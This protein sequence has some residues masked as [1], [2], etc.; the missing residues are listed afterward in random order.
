MFRKIHQTKI[1]QRQNTPC[2]LQNLVAFY[3]KK[4]KAS[5]QQR[6]MCWQAAYHTGALETP[7]T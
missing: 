2:T 7:V 1:F 4:M 5:A 6:N 3:V